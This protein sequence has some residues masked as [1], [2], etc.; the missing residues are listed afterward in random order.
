M[1]RNWLVN[2]GSNTS[3]RSSHVLRGRE[4]IN[5]GFAGS[6]WKAI[7]LRWSFLSSQGIETMNENHKKQYLFFSY[8]GF[9][10]VSWHDLGLEEAVIRYNSRI[11]RGS[12]YGTG[13]TFIPELVRSRKNIV[14]HSH[15]KIESLRLWRQSRHVFALDKIHMR[16]SPQTARFASFNA[17]RTVFSV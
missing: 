3:P 5:L 16:H 9:F 10:S 1:D 11:V 4:F 2:A 17:E 12:L 6:A 15:I 14:L 8:L 7:T 13:M